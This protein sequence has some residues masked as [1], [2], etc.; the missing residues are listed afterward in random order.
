MVS[1]V[2]GI[3]SNCGDRKKN[4]LEAI[5]WLKKELIQVESSDIYETPCALKAGR[6][7]LNAVVKGFY[8]GIGYDL[9]G[10]M[11]DK[12][13]EMGRTT[14]CKE[15]GDVSIDLD[16]VIMDGEIVKD[17]DYR[18]RFFKIGYSQIRNQEG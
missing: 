12:E 11:K 14:D 15:R 16:I 7:Y 1:V 2:I 8:Q 9:E 17:W 5:E 18:Q 4:V 3:G 6:P 13:R 10:L